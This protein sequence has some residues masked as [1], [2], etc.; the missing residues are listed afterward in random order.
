MGQLQCLFKEYK[1]DNVI[2]NWNFIQNVVKN[3]NILS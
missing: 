3:Q 1:S 2:Y